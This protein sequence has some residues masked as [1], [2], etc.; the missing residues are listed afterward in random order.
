VKA[1]NCWRWPL[2]TGWP[3]PPKLDRHRSPLTTRTRSETARFAHV[4]LPAAAQAERA[5]TFTNIERRVQLFGPAV[6]PPGEAR[7]DR[8]IIAEIGRRVSALAARR[9]GAARFAGWAY[10]SPAEVM[11]ELAAL[12]PIYGGISH[13]GLGTA[14]LMLLVRFVI[15]AV[16]AVTL[17]MRAFHGM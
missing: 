5:G 17:A 2:A 9:P 10:G 15:P 1:T 13:A 16:L 4:V 7:P 11:D 6:P 3:R 8:W 12:A 14:G